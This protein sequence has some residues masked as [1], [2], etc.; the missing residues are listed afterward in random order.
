MSPAS[1]QSGGVSS[2]S[3]WFSLVLSPVT[4]PDITVG[5]SRTGRRSEPSRGGRGPSDAGARAAPRPAGTRGA[6]RGSR[7][8]RSGARGLCR[9]GLGVMVMEQVRRSWTLMRAWDSGGSSA[10]RGRSRDP[11]A[12]AGSGPGLDP[13]WLLGATQEDGDWN[14]PRVDAGEGDTVLWPLLAAA[15][16][17]PGQGALCLPTAGA[18]ALPTPGRVRGSGQLRLCLVVP[19]LS[20]NNLYHQAAASL[21]VKGRDGGPPCGKVLRVPAPHSRRGPEEPSDSSGCP[22]GH[23]E[24]AGPHPPACACCSCPQL[25]TCPGLHPC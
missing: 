17:N 25:D 1:P 16:P 23:A 15:P 12:R 19:E 6:L 7:G 22:A 5:S 20:P 21:R 8:S 3:S 24:R 14:P 13:V 2:A 10:G 4:D 18:Q 9:V 11:V